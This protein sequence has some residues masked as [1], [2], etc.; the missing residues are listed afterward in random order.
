MEVGETCPKSG[1]APQIR[2]ETASH[3]SDL[4]EVRC[5]GTTSH[6][7]SAP[8]HQQAAVALMSVHTRAWEADP[9]RISG[10]RFPDPPLEPPQLRWTQGKGD[11]HPSKPCAFRPAPRSVAEANGPLLVEIHAVG[12]VVMQ[13]ALPS[14]DGARNSF[15][16]C[17]RA[18]KQPAPRSPW[19][20][21]C[22]RPSS[23]RS[24]IAGP[25]NYAVAHPRARASCCRLVMLC[26]VC[27]R[28]RSS[29]LTWRR[30]GP[31]SHDLWCRPLGL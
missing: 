10:D 13:R 20:W 3:V 7:N 6:R 8:W 11:K 18:A 4:D 31:R 21:M 26:C 17:R 12:G 9:G 16:A 25:P 24:G 23:T 28:R 29:P 5:G 30:F 19:R 14:F 15:F 2:P 1:G 27:G 22:R